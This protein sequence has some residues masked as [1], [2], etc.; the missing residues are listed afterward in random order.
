MILTGFLLHTGTPVDPRN[1]SI[2]AD[3]AQAAARQAAPPGWHV[4]S[5]LWPGT[6][7]S[8]DRHYIVLI[9]GSGLDERLLRVVL[10]N[11]ETG[12]DSNIP[13]ALEN[14]GISAP[15]TS[16]APG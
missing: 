10:V 16:A 8:T 12:Y 1:P 15:Y 6:N 11:A 2:N 7:Y 3:Q 13:E 9:G 5:M 14:R 4:S